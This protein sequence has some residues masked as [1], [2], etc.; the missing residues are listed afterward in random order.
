GPGPLEVSDPYR[1]LRERRRL[2]EDYL[3]PWREKLARAAAEAEAADRT[4]SP[5]RLLAEPLAAA[6]RTI[7][8]LDDILRTY[9]AKPLVA[10]LGRSDAGKSRMIN[11]LTGIN[12]LPVEW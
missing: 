9:G 1:E 6:H 8:Q 3:R 7:Q 12:M 11:A 10:F 5:S 2:L 4:G